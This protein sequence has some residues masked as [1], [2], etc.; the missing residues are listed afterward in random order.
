MLVLKSAGISSVTS[1]LSF[2]HTSVV[3]SDSFGGPQLAPVR[4]HYKLFLHVPLCPE[5][6]PEVE[7]VAG[8]AADAGTKEPL[9]AIPGW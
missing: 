8:E 3:R 1:L 6:N 5:P 2:H 4:D 9:M 7:G